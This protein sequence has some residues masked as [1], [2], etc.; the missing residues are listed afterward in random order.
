MQI[1]VVGQN[2]APTI[3]QYL[4]ESFGYRYS[5]VGQVVAILLGF[6]VFFAG[7]AIGAFCGQRP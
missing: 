4:V 6:T 1:T 2:G 5:F 3:K 7:L